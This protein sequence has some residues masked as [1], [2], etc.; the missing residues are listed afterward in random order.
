MPYKP[1]EQTPILIS[2][3]HHAMLKQL[4]KSERRTMQ[5]MAEILIEEGSRDRFVRIDDLHVDSEKQ[6][7]FLEKP[8]D[9][10]WHP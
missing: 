3:K 4:A 10:T 5:V 6:D 9:W 1:R 7:R 8:K 2:K